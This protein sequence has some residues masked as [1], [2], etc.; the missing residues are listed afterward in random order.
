MQKVQFNCREML[1]RVALIS[2]LLFISTYAFAQSLVTGVVTDKSG[3]PLIG[4]N[5]LEKGT[6]NGNITDIDGK[7]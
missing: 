2:A 6:T 7:Y 4:V 5:V 1:N 3:E